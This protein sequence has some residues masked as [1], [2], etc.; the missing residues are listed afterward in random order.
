M[1]NVAM[2]LTPESGR[3]RRFD[4]L[5]G[6]GEKYQLH[7]LVGVFSQIYEQGAQK[8]QEIVAGQQAQQQAQQQNRR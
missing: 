3:V 4:T 5:L 8:A 2:D 1:G 6:I 7:Q